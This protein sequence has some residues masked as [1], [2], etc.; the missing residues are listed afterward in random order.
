MWRRLFKIKE[1]GEKLHLISFQR[2]VIRRRLTKSYSSGLAHS[3]N[4]RP[5]DHISKWLETCLLRKHQRLC[6][7]SMLWKQKGIKTGLSSNVTCQNTFILF[8]LLNFMLF[9]TVILNH[10]VKILHL[11]VTNFDTKIW[12]GWTRT[13]VFHRTAVNLLSSTNWVTERVTVSR[14]NVYV[15]GIDFCINYYRQRHLGELLQVSHY[16]LFATF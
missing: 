6:F 2:C 1:T 4:G 8:F 13:N 7:V 9:Y 3:G 16:V 15:L 14:E 11:F 12:F 5:P 10:F